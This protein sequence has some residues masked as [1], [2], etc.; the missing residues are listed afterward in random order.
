MPT[1]NCPECLSN[2][3]LNP[4]LSGTVIQCPQCSKPV[5][6]PGSKNAEAKDTERKVEESP[7]LAVLLAVL[8]GP[9]GLLYSTT[10]GALVMFVVA[11]LFGLFS[12]PIAATLLCMPLCGLIAYAAIT[13]QVTIMPTTEPTVVGKSITQIFKVQGSWFILAGVVTLFFTIFI[14]DTTVYMP[15]LGQ[16]VYNSG[17]QSYQLIFSIVGCLLVLCGV[18]RYTLR[19][20]VIR[21]G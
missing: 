12:N 1:F 13:N 10:E 5:R 17:L 16:H 4:S 20:S 9:L 14:F 21:E 15:E 3:E 6:L 18:I 8:F 2:I 11:I 7:T 19:N